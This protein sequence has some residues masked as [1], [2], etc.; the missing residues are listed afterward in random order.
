MNALVLDPEAHPPDVEL[1]E[2]MNPTG[3]ERPA[4]VGADRP[5]QAE[6]AEGAFEDRAD[7]ATLGRAQAAAG[8]QVAGVLIGEREL[9]A[10][11]LPGR[12]LPFEIGG[13]E[14]SQE[15]ATGRSLLWAMGL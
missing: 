9:V 1:L 13:P 12:E 6:L 3:G 11:D 15:T 14:I 2:P 10:P 8:K 5:G 7:A 4:V